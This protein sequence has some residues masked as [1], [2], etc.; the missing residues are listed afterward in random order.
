MKSIKCEKCG[1][2]LISL[3]YRAWDKKK[4]KMANNTKIE[5]MYCRTCKKPTEV[6][7]MNWFK[8]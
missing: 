8:E 1:D 3:F 7:V 2:R 5:Q 6:H 4:Q